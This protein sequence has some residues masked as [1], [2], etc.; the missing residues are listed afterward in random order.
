MSLLNPIFWLI[1][2]VLWLYLVI[3]FLAVIMSWLISFSVINTSNRFVYMVADTLHRITEP[4]LR[5]IRRFMPDLG[6]LDISPIVLLLVVE[7]ARRVS[8]E[9]QRLL[10][11]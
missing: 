11:V 10:F 3:V 2:Q 6:G 7:F 9:I 4:A 8:H 5:P 1:D